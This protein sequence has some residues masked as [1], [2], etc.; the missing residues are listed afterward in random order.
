MPCVIKLQVH[1][2]RG[3]SCDGDDESGGRYVEASLHSQTQYSSKSTG[4]LDRLAWTGW[5][6]MELSD[7]FELQDH[8]LR[9]GVCSSEQGPPDSG[10]VAIDLEQILHSAAGS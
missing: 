9:L 10:S 4:P 5:L 2:A 7:D 3:L 1:Q 8:P 6:R